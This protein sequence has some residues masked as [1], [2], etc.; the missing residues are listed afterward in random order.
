MYFTR[1]SINILFWIKDTILTVKIKYLLLTE[2]E[3]CTVSYG[4]SFFYAVLCVEMLKGITFE[5]QNVF[6]IKRIS[7]RLSGF[8]IIIIVSLSLIRFK[9]QTNW[10]QFILMNPNFTLSSKSVFF[11]WVVICWFFYGKLRK[12]GG[13]IWTYNIPSLFCR[14]SVKNLFKKSPGR[15][16]QPEGASA[17][18]TVSSLGNLFCMP[19]ETQF[20]SLCFCESDWCCVIN[21]TSQFFSYLWN[22]FQSMS[23]RSEDFSSL[24]SLAWKVD[25]RTIL[26]SLAGLTGK[27]IQMSDRLFAMYW[28]LHCRCKTFVKS[29]FN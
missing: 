18:N 27:H 1:I 28:N 11:C 19:E 23:S 12:K 5:G 7:T 16:M 15:S 4:P 6:L 17:P 3:V 29:A 26:I 24:S 9:R 20:V 8:S 22:D 13:L 14:Q 25:R 2:F 21:C 10:V